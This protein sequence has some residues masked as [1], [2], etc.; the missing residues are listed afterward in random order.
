MNSKQHRAAR[1][2][3]LAALIWLLP[4]AMMAQSADACVGYWKTVDD[5]TNQTRSVVQIYKENGTYHGTI[6]KLFRQ[7][8]EERDPNCDEC[9]DDDPAA[10]TTATSRWR[11]KT[12]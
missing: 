10:S 4:A 6:V 9:D 5:E 7:P 11:A 3:L 1:G 12:K 8:D 2:W